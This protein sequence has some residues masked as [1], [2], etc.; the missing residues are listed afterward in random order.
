MDYLRG[1]EWRRWDLHLHT[2]ETKKNDQYAGASAKEKWDAFYLVDSLT[3]S[4]AVQNKPVTLTR[5]V[6]QLNW[7]TQDSFEASDH[8][9]KV[10]LSNVATAFQPLTG[11][12]SGPKVL[13]FTLLS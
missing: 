8:Q 4:N 6:G 10:T 13:S 2:P 5:P 12:V 3:I 7:A 11:T 9:V 1:S